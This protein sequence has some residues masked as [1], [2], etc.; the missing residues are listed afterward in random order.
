ML[1]DDT[2]QLLHYFPDCHLASCMPACGKMLIVMLIFQTHMRVMKNKTWK[3]S[4]CTEPTYV[5]VELFPLDFYLH[6]HPSLLFFLKGSLSLNPIA[7][8]SAC[9]GFKALLRGQA[10]PI[11]SPTSWLF[12]R[13][14]AQQ[15]SF[16]NTQI[17]VHQQRD[18][19]LAKEPPAPSHCLVLSLSLSRSSPWT[20]H[21][22]LPTLLYRP[23]YTHILASP[24]FHSSVSVIRLIFHRSSH[25]PLRS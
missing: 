1:A 9:G 13:A 25:T 22:S 23:H 4:C 11:L 16:L 7:F 8:A 15:C 20:L 24:S 14:K 18:H 10:W 12:K 19:C 5:H 17:H 3:R 2:K 21:L 6:L